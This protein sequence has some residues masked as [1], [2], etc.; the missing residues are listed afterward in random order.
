MTVT[1]WVQAISALAIAVLTAFLYKITVNYAKAT[2]RMADVMTREFELRVSPLLDIQGGGGTSRG[3]ISAVRHVS[4]RN[5]GSYSLTV[6]R[7]AFTY[8]PIG[9]EAHQRHSEDFAGVHLLEAGGEWRRD[10]NLPVGNIPDELRRGGNA[11][12]NVGYRISVTVRNIV[13]E[14]RV[15][16]TP[17]WR[18]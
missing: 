9:N 16:H 13:G 1:D 12:E 3:W 14:E 11:S 2:K 5:I 10:L 7:I 15:V 6:E 4:L 17:D 8:W 18:M